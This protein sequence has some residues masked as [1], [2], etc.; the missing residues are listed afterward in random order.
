MN[1]EAT[2]LSIL[3]QGRFRLQ[4]QEFLLCRAG[5]YVLGSPG[6]SHCWAAESDCTVIMIRWP[7]KPGDGVAVSNV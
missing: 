1:V 7:S 5:D 2:T 4:E 3:V 6:V